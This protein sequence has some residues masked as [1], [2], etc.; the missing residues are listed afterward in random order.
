MQSRCAL[1]ALCADLW[2]TVGGILPDAVFS[3]YCG[4]ISPFR[5][6]K[7]FISALVAKVPDTVILTNKKGLSRIYQT[8]D[9]ALKK[10]FF[11]FIR[12]EYFILTLCGI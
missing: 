12:M 3:C 5:N 1:E 7:Y 10:C 8:W 11:S 4:S 6:S 2:V 9:F